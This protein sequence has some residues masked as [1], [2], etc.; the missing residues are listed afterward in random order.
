MFK[1]NK[2]IYANFVRKINLIQKENYYLFIYLFIYF[3]I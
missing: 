2:Y 3:Y 1:T